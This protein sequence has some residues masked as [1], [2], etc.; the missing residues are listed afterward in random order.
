MSPAAVDR[1][2][3]EWLD[4]WDILKAEEAIEGMHMD[5]LLILRLMPM[6][7]AE[8]VEEGPK[9]RRDILMVLVPAIAKL[10]NLICKVK[11]KKV[12]A[13]LLKGCGIEEVQ[14]LVHV[15]TTWTEADW[16]PVITRPYNEWKGLIKKS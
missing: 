6:P 11:S 16:L 14:L 5:V 7:L 10:S 15:L 4:V 8:Y 9:Q 12:K 3:L 1:A 13:D 2:L